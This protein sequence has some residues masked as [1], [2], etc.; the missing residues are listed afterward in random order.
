MFIT[1]TPVK[2]IATVYTLRMMIGLST[3]SL[4][5]FMDGTYIVIICQM[6][7]G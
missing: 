1:I 3:L 6:I 4:H 5:N 2:R 7:I